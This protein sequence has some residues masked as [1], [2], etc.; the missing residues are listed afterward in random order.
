MKKIIFLFSILIL[1]CSKPSDCIESAGKETT[2][3][4]SVAAFDKIKVFKGIN[5]QN[6]IIDSKFLQT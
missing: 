2:K 4:F 5:I 1:G 6:K 3:E